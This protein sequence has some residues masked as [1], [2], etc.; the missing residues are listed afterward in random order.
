MA[1]FDL[2]RDWPVAAAGLAVAGG[3]ALYVTGRRSEA[4]NQPVA[5]GASEQAYAAAV[6]AATSVEL[7]RQQVT[8]QVAAAFLATEAARAQA[9]STERI[10]FARLRTAETI[11][12]EQAAAARAQAELAAATSRAQIAAQQQSSLFGFLGNIVT[13][14]LPFL[15]SVERTNEAMLRTR[16]GWR[17]WNMLYQGDYSALQTPAA[18]ATPGIPRLRQAAA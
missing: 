18:G 13:G 12:S 6:Q 10:E 5:V 17:R 2:K 8:G 4:F 14:I 11:V 16:R 9:A 7:G 3:V 1:T 15:F